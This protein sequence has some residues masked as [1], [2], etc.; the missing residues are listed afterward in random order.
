MSFRVFSAMLGSLVY[1]LEKTAHTPKYIV[2]RAL[3]P[4]ELHHL[5]DRECPLAATV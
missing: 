3:P 4:T 5:G 1:R 2:S